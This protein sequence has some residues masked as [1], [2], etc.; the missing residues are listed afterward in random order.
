M[1]AKGRHEADRSPSAAGKWKELLSAALMEFDESKLPERILAARNEIV[2]RTQ[3]LGG[4]L[5][6]TQEKIELADGLSA[7]RALENI[8]RTS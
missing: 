2:Q 7:L 5:G 4:E 1:D 8:T 6:Y 3:E